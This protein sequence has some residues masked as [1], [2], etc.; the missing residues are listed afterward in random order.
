MSITTSHLPSYAI[1]T[2]EQAERYAKYTEQGNW[3]LLSYEVFW[4]ERFDFLKDRGYIL[5]PRFKPEWTPSW[6]GTNRHP[7]FCEDSIRSMVQYTRALSIP[8]TK[9]Y[10]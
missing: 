7:N 10:S 4:R 2:P 8:S 5:R 3:N 6:I 9:P 1:L